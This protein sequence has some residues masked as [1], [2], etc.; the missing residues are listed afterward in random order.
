MSFS[1]VFL[2]REGSVLYSH[3]RNFGGMVFPILGGELQGW[4]RL[5]VKSGKVRTTGAGER[6]FN[7]ADPQFVQC[8]LVCRM[9]GYFGVSWTDEFLPWHADVYRL[10]ESSA[11][12]S[13]FLGWRK[14]ALCDGDPRAVLRVFRDI[15]EEEC[16]S[17]RET[18]W[19]LGDGIAIYFEPHLSY[20]PEK[21]FRIHVLALDRESDLRVKR[22]LGKAGEREGG[23]FVRYLGGVVGG[24]GECPFSDAGEY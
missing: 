21:S 12:W 22:V 7:F 23:L 8:G 20:F 2:E 4:I 17:S 9:D 24:P 6:I 5:G 18:S 11:V 19:W 1:Q 10:I 3:E 15:Y 16:T 14:S 13:N